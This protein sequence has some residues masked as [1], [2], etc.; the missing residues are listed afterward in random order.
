MKYW[1][2]YDEGKTIGTIG[3]ENGV[4]FLDDEHTYGA[5]VTLEKKES[6]VIALTVGIYGAGMFSD[7][8]KSEDVARKWVY[9]IEKEI[10]YGFLLDDG[11]DF[12]NWLEDFFSNYGCGL[13]EE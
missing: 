6:G 8:T 11:P 7:W 12:D 2:P 9:K 13:S 1:F 5:R 4:I 10:G 3:V